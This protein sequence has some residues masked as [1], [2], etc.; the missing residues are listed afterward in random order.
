MP[1]V[2]D[3][4]LL[5]A[6]NGGGQQ[7]P[8]QP[9][10]PGVIEGNPDPFKQSA[11][12]RAQA[13]EARANEDQAMQRQRFA[14]DQQ[15]L[16]LERER[17][18]QEGIKAT[19]EQNKAAGFLLRA[20]KSNDVYEAQQ[21]GPRSLVGQTLS[22]VAPGIL[23]TL[24]SDIG[25]SP[26]RQV[27]DVTQ[28]DFIAAT[29]RYESGAAIPAT[30]LEAQRRRYFP[31]PGDG[32]EALA[33]KAELRRTAIE[34]LKTSAGAIGEKTFQD[35]VGP[36]DEGLTGG[37]VTDDRP[38]QDIVGTLNPGGGSPPAGGAPTD[39]PPSFRSTQDPGGFSGLASLAT[40]GVTLGLSDEAAGIGNY[41][42]A[43]LTG[44]NPADAYVAG[45]DSQR[46]FDQ[47]A[48]QQWGLT[49]GAMELLGGG[50]AARIASL[51]ST[52]G[53]AA[54]QGA[55]I[56]GAAGFGA[57]EGAQGSTMNALLGA[58]VGGALGAGG[59][60]VG[61]A[62]AARATRNAPG[63]AVVQA[64]QRQ[65]IPIRQPDARP[66]LRGQ[67]AQAESTQTGGPMIRATR[68]ADANAIEQRIA[69]VG[70]GGNPSDPYAL[71]TR[72]QEAGQRY[73][74]RTKAQATRLYDRARELAGD[75][76]VTARNADAALDQNIQELRAAGE[77]SNAAAIGYLEGLRDDI[78]RG[79]S[80]QAVQNLRTNMRGQ[81]SERGLTATD[82]ERRVGQV[83]DAMNQDL[84]EQLPREAGD[85][86]RAADSF[87]RERQTFIN[88]TLKQFM[89]DRGNPL[90]AETAAQRLVS[91]A[92]GKGNY[93]RFSRMWQQLEPTEQ[94][95]VS[96]TI[97]AS[98]GRKA[99]GD[100]SVATLIRSL[101]PS[102]GINPRTARLVFGEDGA[103]ALQ[104][105]RVI[106]QAKTETMGRQSPSGVAIN[107]GASGLKKL[108]W[109]ALGMIGGGPGG[110][111]AGAVG[112][113]F[114][115]Q[116]GEQRA[117]R[118][119]LNPDFTRWLRNAPNATNPQAIDR[120]FSKLA[121]TGIAA[122]DNAA[123]TQ[124]LMAAFKQSPGRAAAQDEPNGRRVPP[125]Q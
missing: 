6:L 54:R 13:G 91:I 18:K 95:D 15:K 108:L 19:G 24:P 94:A 67:M 53:G 56:G 76:T 74:A 70:G 7:Q 75:A 90:P 37:V 88:N 10:F 38:E 49:G 16:E 52:I 125:Q 120:Y 96:A 111:A 17:V 43:L 34:A 105:L 110:A 57:G 114:F 42:G 33:A 11:E 25:N 32:P 51:P 68:E 39:G 78:D 72:V 30:E 121:T 46:Q 87:Y 27:S 14:Q 116:W 123:F 2:T 106:A 64:G 69:E 22:E 20:L 119:L 21:I 63:M 28:D 5:Q 55:A 31:M 92:Q 89:G 118:M 23:N 59:Q 36:Q 41:L 62:L 124:A 77:N 84:T 1:Q 45:R 102:K 9:R 4:A 29:L 80:L 79:L 97:A 82:T 93:D 112:Q 58:G 122:N 115:Q 35:F 73:I 109:G 8:R 104:D 61:N 44:Q 107:A 103:R 101:D 113:S 50:G 60:Y 65:N 86:L 100:F 66:D 3:P 40:R 98:L 83:L 71:G 12:A 26:Q 85:A 48:A 47:Q 117:A 81:I 99:N